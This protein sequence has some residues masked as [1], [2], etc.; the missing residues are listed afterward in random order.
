MQAADSSC[1]DA[2]N[3]S[4][5]GSVDRRRLNA[6]TGPLRGPPAHREQEIDEDSDS[7]AFVALRPGGEGPWL[8][9]PRAQSPKPRAFRLL[10]GPGAS[11]RGRRPAPGRGRAAARCRWRAAAR[12]IPD[13]ACSRWPGASPALSVSTPSATTA[14]PSRRP[15]STIVRITASVRGRPSPARRGTTIELQSIHRQ[16]VHVAERGLARAEVVD[17]QPEAQRRSSSRVRCAAGGSVITE[18]SVSSNS[19]RSW[20]TPALSAMAATSAASPARRA[21]WPTG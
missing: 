7:R 6:F 19:M 3:V 14:M 16:P 8:A 13:R 12:D 15:S 2:K 21:V 18:L 5:L 17:A 20:G 1:W 11:V 9:T 10:T 4:T